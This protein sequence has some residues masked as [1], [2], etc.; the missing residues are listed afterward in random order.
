MKVGK[1]YVIK[2]IKGVWPSLKFIW[3]NDPFY[4]LPSRAEVERVVGIVGVEML[5]WINYLFDCDDFS[6]QL[7]ARVSLFRGVE[8]GKGNI[9]VDQQFPWPFGQTMGTVFQGESDPHKINICVVKGEILLIEPQDS[10]IWQANAK[11]DKP[12]FIEF[13]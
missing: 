3:P 8:T 4:W 9:P 7:S 5:T 12:F 11:Q 1:D 10:S 13:P 6:L 2:E